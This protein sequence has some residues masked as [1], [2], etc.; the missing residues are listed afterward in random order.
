MFFS[1]FQIDTL[2]ACGGFVKN[3]VF[4][5]E[6]ADIMG[7]LI[8]LYTHSVYFSFCVA[9]PLLIYAHVENSCMH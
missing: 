2:L 4:L 7:T 9:P 6:Q 5:Q 3:S 1:L 8:L